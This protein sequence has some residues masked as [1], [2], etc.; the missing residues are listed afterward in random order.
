MGMEEG[1]L[2]DREAKLVYVVGYTSIEA[3]KLI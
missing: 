2:Q 1:G 3:V